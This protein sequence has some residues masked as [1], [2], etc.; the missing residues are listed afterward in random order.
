MFAMHIDHAYVFE[1]TKVSSK[2]QK[3][4]HMKLLR[5]VHLYRQKVREIHANMNIPDNH[6]IVKAKF[7]NYTIDHLDTFSTL[8]QT[9]QTS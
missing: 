2:H 1:F 4:F 3:E 9:V 6:A 5:C 8:V 7:F